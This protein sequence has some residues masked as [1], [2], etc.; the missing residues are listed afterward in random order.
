MPT[1]QPQPLLPPSPS[2][3]PSLSPS[4]QQQQ[5]QQQGKQNK[6]Q[7]GGAGRST[8]SNMP[9]A[10]DF[11]N[12]MPRHNHRCATCLLGGDLLCCDTCNCVFHL[13]CLPVPLHGVPE[14][15]WR[16]HFCIEEDLPGTSTGTS[17]GTSA[18]GAT[19][20][21]AVVPASVPT[22]VPSFV[23]TPK[24]RKNTSGAPPPSPAAKRK[25]MRMRKK[26]R[27][28]QAQAQQAEQAAGALHPP[29]PSSP[30]SPPARLRGRG[31]A[32][33]YEIFGRGYGEEGGCG[34]GRRGGRGG[35]GGRGNTSTMLSFSWDAPD[36]LWH[37]GAAGGGGGRDGGSDG[38]SGGDGGGGAV[39]GGRLSVA[40]TARAVAAATNIAWT[41]SV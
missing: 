13:Q 11:A 14:G 36:G 37:A 38:G 2:L 18:S 7:K 41:G 10:T 32:R 17:G 40:E 1:P 33:A 31:L 28:T 35:G 20:K 3:S 24:Q 21:A 30:P 5:Q 27:K 25:K 23:S 4:Q 15:M 19:R 6:Q 9:R 34:V 22:F 16:C 29:S 8:A 26:E 39:V 12:N